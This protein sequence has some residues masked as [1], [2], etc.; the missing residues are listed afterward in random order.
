[1][2]AVSYC[3]WAKYRNFWWMVCY[4]MT[5]TG[6][7][8]RPWKNSCD[9]PAI[10]TDFFDWGFGIALYSLPEHMLEVSSSVSVR[11]MVTSD[12]PGSQLRI[13]GVGVGGADGAVHS[14]V[15]TLDGDG[16]WGEW[17][18]GSS[19]SSC[20]KV[21]RHHQRFTVYFETFHRLYREHLICNLLSQ[22]F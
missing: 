9:V 19:F 11:S 7:A 10:N 20:A 12:L 3:R 21:F 6:F 17:S 14:S 22:P 5:S 16:G 1:M 8:T 18:G 13:W 15:S 2:F 4:K